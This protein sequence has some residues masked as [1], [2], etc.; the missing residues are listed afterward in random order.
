[1]K[2]VHKFRDTIHAYKVDS[3]ISHYNWLCKWVNKYNEDKYRL[4]DY[5]VKVSSMSA[6]YKHKDKITEHWHRDVWMENKYN[7]NFKDRIE[8]GCFITYK[9]NYDLSWFLDESSTCIE[10]SNPDHYQIDL[11]DY[12]GSKSA[13]EDNYPDGTIG[14]FNSTDTASEDLLITYW[15]IDEK[16]GL[17]A[18]SISSWDE[19]YP[20]EEELRAY[21]EK[22]K[23]EREDE[24][25]ANID[26]WR[27]FEH[28][29]S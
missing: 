19:E 23:N 29:I 17:G 27:D 3:L 8:N 14:G 2:E 6:H 16:G 10:L 21:K 24:R 26:S 18:G 7:I 1:M 22:L 15:R 11:N 20:S 12:L 4:W 5:T 25:L 28:E 13:F 9:A